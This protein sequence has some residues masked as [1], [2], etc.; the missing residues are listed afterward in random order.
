MWLLHIGGTAFPSVKNSP[1]NE[2]RGGDPRWCSEYTSKV[3]Y[4]M[5]IYIYILDN[6]KNYGYCVCVPFS[7]PSISI[8]IEFQEKKQHWYS[9]QVFFPWIPPFST[10]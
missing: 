5:Y 7:T 3:R 4:I 8:R 1:T 10:V 2:P 6:K 9:K